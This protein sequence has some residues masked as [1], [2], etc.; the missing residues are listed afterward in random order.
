MLIICKFQQLGWSNTGQQNIDY[1][2]SRILGNEMSWGESQLELLG[3]RE[4]E[5]RVDW[6]NIII[7]IK[8]RSIF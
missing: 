2:P 4:G 8:F 3:V 1:L 7:N 5:W 6:I